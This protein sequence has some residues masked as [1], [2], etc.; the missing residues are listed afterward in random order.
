VSVVYKIIAGVLANRLNGVAKKIIS[1]PYDTFVKGKQILHSVLIATECLDS[2]IGSSEPRVLYKLDIEKAY[3]H[4]NWDFLLY[5]LRRCGFGE[6]WHSWITHCIFS[7][8]FSV[9]V[10]GTPSSFLRS[11]VMFSLCYCYGGLK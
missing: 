7:I 6:K 4:V 11:F 2:R 1:K 3:N 8:C 10:N 9:L 5:L